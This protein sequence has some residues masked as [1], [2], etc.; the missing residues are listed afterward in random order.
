[1]IRKGANRQDGSIGRVAGTGRYPINLA[2]GLPLQALLES[3][4]KGKAK[5]RAKALYDLKATIQ[6]VFGASGMSSPS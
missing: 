5:V 6:R 4:G 2:R 3:E 1:V